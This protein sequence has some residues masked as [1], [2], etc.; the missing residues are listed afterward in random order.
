MVLSGITVTVAEKPLGN[1]GSSLD[2]RIK[3]IKTCNL[4]L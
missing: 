4:V 3:V 2:V 1:Y